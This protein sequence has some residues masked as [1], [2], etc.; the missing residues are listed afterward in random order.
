MAAVLGVLGALGTARG[1]SAY[2]DQFTLSGDVGLHLAPTE[3]AALPGERAPGRPRMPPGG[4]A[5]GL[6]A[7]LGVS[8]AVSLGARL[9]YAAQLDAGDGQHV[10]V[11]SLALEGFYLLDI[12]KLVPFFGGGIDVLAEFDA[13]EAPGTVDPRFDL[14]VHGLLGLDYL[15]S[16]EWL[17]G[18]D[19]RVLWHPIS[20]GSAVDTTT[21]RVRLLVTLR[22]SRIFDR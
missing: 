7:T 13:F 19:I 22:V 4:L 9:G 3:G 20:F 12:L 16:R 14:G 2:E 5:L 1:A 18:L 8:D 15:L 21:E 17:L 6:G 10:H 11:T